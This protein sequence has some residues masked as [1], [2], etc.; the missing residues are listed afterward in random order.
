MKKFLLITLIAASLISCSESFLEERPNSN[1]LTPKTAEDFQR[2]LDNSETI[3]ITSVLPQLAADEYYI[4]S[5]SSWRS[6]RTATE[7]HS[8]IWDIDVF[9]GEV[10]LED[11]NAPYRTIF[12][13][14]NILTEIDKSRTEGGH[15]NS[16]DDIY[17]QALFHRAKANYDLLKNFSVPFDPATQE[18]DL[19]IPLR[20]DPSIDYTV[21]R[22][23]VKGCYDHIFNDL[24]R[25]LQYLKYWGPLPERNRATRLAT[26]ALLSRIHLYRREYDKAEQFA[27]SV[28]NRYDK[29]IDYNTI[30]LTSNTPFIRTNDELIMFG[31]TTTYNNASQINLTETV[32]VDSTLIKLY[33]PNDLRLSIYFI[34]DTENRFRM[35]RGYNGAGLAPFNG[36]AVDEVLLIKAECLVRRYRL[37]EA[38]IL[39]NRLLINRYKK[40]EYQQVIFSDPHNAL[41][42]VL[43]ERRK[44]LIWRC[45]RWD[46]IKRLNKERANIVLTRIV[47][48]NI[49]R[50]E[51]NSNRY[52][53]NIPQ[54]EIN[55]SGITQNIR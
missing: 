48:E 40:D 4:D 8:Y 54:D 34:N 38:S 53:F 51:P 45:L 11:W 33:H 39:M 10:N 26:Y 43:T 47:G 24:E 52:V 19:G 41:N 15:D 18:T 3:G 35:K 55:R 9:G 6:A 22:S 23:T 21:E 1:I 13:A 7:R 5:E 14:N 25:S 50:L 31:L 49:Y 37:D 32:F 29:L 16:L 28:L 2:L 44:E 12:Y 46:D 20:E 27:D 42:F 17:G 36:L 30:S